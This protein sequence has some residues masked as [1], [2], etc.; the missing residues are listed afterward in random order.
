MFSRDR[1]G[2]DHLMRIV[3]FT[4]DLMFPSRVSVVARRLNVPLDVVAS[5]EALLAKIAADTEPPLVVLLDLNCALV[6]AG[7]TMPQL[8]SLPCPPKTIAFGPHVHEAKLAAAREAGCDVVLTRGQFDAQ[9][10]A[11]LKKFLT[12]SNRSDESSRM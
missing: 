4:T 1:R 9:M 8:K 5:G 10:E 12:D 6:D 2:S 11:V 3:F 7:R